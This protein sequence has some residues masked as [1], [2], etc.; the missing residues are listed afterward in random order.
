MREVGMS[1]H[2]TRCCQVSNL[3]HILGH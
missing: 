1:S 3:F 2:V